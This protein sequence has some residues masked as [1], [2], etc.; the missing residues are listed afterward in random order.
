MNNT[1]TKKENPKPNPFFHAYHTI[2]PTKN[3]FLQE[4]DGGGCYP[5][6]REGSAHKKLKR[7][8]LRGEGPGGGTHPGPQRRLCPGLAGERKPLP[9]KRPGQLTAVPLPL[10]HKANRG[11]LEGGPRARPCGF[12]FVLPRYASRTLSSLRSSWPVPVRV[13]LPVWST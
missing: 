12:Y 6:H 5:L 3:Q 7:L 11:P 2:K 9:S 4:T 8:C 1:K 10:P 13:M